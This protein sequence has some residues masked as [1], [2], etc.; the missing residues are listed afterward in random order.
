MP[1]AP[2]HARPALAGSRGP[3][4]SPAPARGPK[5]VAQFVSHPRSG[6]FTGGRGPYVRAGRGRWRPVVNRGA[7]YSK[8]CEGASL[9]W[10]QNPTSTATD[11][12]EHRSWQPVGGRVVLLWSHLLVS[13][14]S[15]VRSARRDQPRLLCLVTGA[16]EQPWTALNRSTHAAAACTHHSGLA[17]NVR[18]R[19]DA[20]QLTQRITLSDRKVP[21]ER[22]PSGRSAC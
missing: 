5:A 15:R 2:N 11:L 7:Q 10:V 22:L 13:V 18:D 9:P 6:Q 12:Q 16:P 8:A 14:T 17:G 3:L 19:P 1:L 21:G 20:R 4:A